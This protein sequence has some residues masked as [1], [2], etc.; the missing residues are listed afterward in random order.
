MQEELRRDIRY[1]SSQK[2][3]LMNKSERGS[4]GVITNLSSGGL[5]I[6]LIG[7]PNPLAAERVD[8][9]VNRQTLLCNVVSS[10]K[11]GLHCRFD[12]SLDEPL[13]ASMF[14]Y[15]P[16]PAPAWG[17]QMIGEDSWRLPP[18][19]TYD[20]TGQWK[21][22]AMMSES[23]VDGTTLTRIYTEGCFVGRE[24]LDPGVESMY[25]TAAVLNPYHAAD[26]RHHWSQGFTDAVR[27]MT[28]SRRR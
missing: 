20:R 4:F 26:E 7:S 19:T 16:P 17:D 27:H 1:L 18:H 11:E 24:Q 23:R 2:A 15:A 21:Y 28:R 13:M 9:K 12:D 3:V 6:A 25:A 14:Q 8:L 22:T 10:G 5:C